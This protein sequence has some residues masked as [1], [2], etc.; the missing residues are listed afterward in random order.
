[1]LKRLLFVA[2]LLLLLLEIGG[3]VVAVRQGLH[4]VRVARAVPTEARAGL[5][6]LSG[7]SPAHLD[8]A[9]LGRA[10]ADFTAAGNGAALLLA[11]A[12]RLQPLLA[13][14]LRRPAVALEYR[15]SVAALTAVADGSSLATT[16]LHTLPQLLP[17]NGSAG[18]NRQQ[19]LRRLQ[20][21][22]PALAAALVTTADID[23]ELQQVRAG[24][25]YRSLQPT[26]RQEQQDLPLAQAALRL[27]IVA[28]GLLGAAGPQSYLVVAQDP[29]DLRPTGG[30]LGSW[31]ILT[32]DQGNITSLSYKSYTAWEDV[33]DPQRAWP[34]QTPP[35]QRYYGYC[36]MDMQDANWY[37]DFPTTARVL[38]LFAEADQPAPLAG[39][40]AFDPALVQALLQVTGPVT[41]P[42]Q[43]LTVTAANVVDLA[44]YF[45]GRGATPP[46]PTMQLGKQFL[47]L[48]AQALAA[49]LSTNPHV[50]LT[51]LAGALL[52]LL[53]DKHVLLAVDNP[54]AAAVVAG[55]GWDGAVATPPG[56]YL[57]LDEMSM[58]DNKVDGSISRRLD[59]SVKVTAAGG[60]DVTLRYTVANRF[61]LPVDPG[62]KTTAFR[63]YFRFYLPPGATVGSLAGADDVAAPGTESGHVVAAGFLVVARG[64]SRTITLQYHV[65]AAVVAGPDGAAYVLH[66]QVQ[67]GIPP[68]AFHVQVTAPNG[69]VVANRTATLRRDQAWSF[70]VAAA[71]P[72]APP[73]PAWD[74]TC[75]AYSLVA[76]LKGPY[77]THRVQIP[78]GC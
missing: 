9:A 63:D 6:E 40:I 47:V 3:A 76:G 54:D 52:P 44:N 26:L 39:V 49:R 35:V 13:P 59:D 23:R 38:Q 70:P 58:S 69:N 25:L 24:R 60:A 61:P 12:D 55:L 37:P 5:H 2:G 50:S 72:P 43:H 10:Q 28:P 27:A 30:F 48:V 65:P 21:A 22:G 16:A 56:D 45:E 73:T 68:L 19:A 67:P 74:R 31:G 32:V 57:L 33:R 15:Q 34:L 64:Q 62:A 1:M 8:P 66:V 14:A 46:P 4:L 20:E 41:L 75:A 11:A 7:L 18:L 53:N 51:A 78:A 42:A 77:S 36:C 29:A 71:I 17:E